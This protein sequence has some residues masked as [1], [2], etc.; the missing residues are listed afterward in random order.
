MLDVGHVDIHGEGQV[1]FKDGGS[2][3]VE[4]EGLPI[5]MDGFKCLYQKLEFPFEFLV[6]LSSNLIAKFRNKFCIKFVV[7]NKPTHKLF[8]TISTYIYLL[9]SLRM[10]HSKL[11]SKIVKP[12]LLLSFKPMGMMY[13]LTSMGISMAEKLRRIGAYLFRSVL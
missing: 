8:H 10:S 5:F 4:F 2:L 13:Y 12:L 9:F 6:D 7:L 1:L 11:S 3:S